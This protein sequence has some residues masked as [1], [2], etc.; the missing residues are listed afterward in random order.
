MYPV[1]PG[2]MRLL[3]CNVLQYPRV[4]GIFERNSA[5]TVFEVHLLPIYIIYTMH[6]IY[7]RVGKRPLKLSKDFIAPIEYM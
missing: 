5:R 1:V 2:S 3:T 6:P 7:L 4:I